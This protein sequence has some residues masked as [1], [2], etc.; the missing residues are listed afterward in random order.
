[1]L[2]L[3]PKSEFIASCIWFQKNEVLTA[4]EV[5]EIRQ[6]RQHR[7]DIAHEMPNILLNPLTQ[8]DEAKLMRIH[9]LVSKIDRWWITE[10]EMPCNEEFDGQKVD[11]T[12][13]KS[14]RMRFLEHLIS[15]VYECGRVH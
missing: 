3:D 11:S 5:K 1:V 10:I 9:E 8:V 12:E 15:A 7:T 2:S 13:I 14:G 4:D 6:I